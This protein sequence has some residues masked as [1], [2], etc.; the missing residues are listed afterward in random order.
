MSM[1]S[2]QML[3]RL[4]FMVIMGVVFTAPSRIYA[5]DGAAKPSDCLPCELKCPCCQ[6][7]N[8]NWVNEKWVKIANMSV[9]AA[10]KDALKAKWDSAIPYTFEAG[11]GDVRTDFYAVIGCLAPAQDAET[12]LKAIRDDPIRFAGASSEF[13]KEIG[14]HPAGRGGR[15]LYDIV[16]LNIY[17]PDNGAIAYIDVD[18]SDGEFCAVTVANARSGT[19]PVSGMRCWGFTYLSECEVMFY[20]YSIESANIAGFGIP[21]GLF[22]DAVWKDLM[23]AIRDE[24]ARQGGTACRIYADDEWQSKDS[25]LK[26]RKAAGKEIRKSHLDGTGGIDTVEK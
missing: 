8:P 23:R 25:R 26:K 21:G 20:T 15:R 5:D 13:A 3:W 24:I 14:W 4:V 17:G 22:Q 19:H 16:N 7:P 9:S 10:D 1:K 11:W 2:C 6:K 18:T 12:M